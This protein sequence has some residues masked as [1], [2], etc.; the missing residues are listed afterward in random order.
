[1]NAQL[2]IECYRDTKN[3]LERKNYINFHKKRDCNLST[4]NNKKD[5]HRGLVT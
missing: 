2:I 4:R 1:M 3:T 5:A